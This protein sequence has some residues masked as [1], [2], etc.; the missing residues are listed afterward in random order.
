MKKLVLAAFALTA[1]ASVFAQGTVF[2]NNRIAGG[3][4]TGL[5]LHVF[6]P[7]TTA[8][9]LS[10]IGL[11][12]NDTGGS[13]NVTNAWGS[14]APQSANLGSVS[15][16]PLIGAGGS[17]GKYGYATTFAQLI[18]A[19]GLNAAEGSL[20]P[21][22]PTTTFRTGSSLGSVAVMSVTLS[23]IPKDAAA[24]TFEFVAWDASAAIAGYDLTSWGIAGQKKAFDAWQAG[25]IAGGHSAPFNST[26]I[27]GDLNPIINLN[28]DSGN[29]GGMTSFNLYMIPE[30]STFALA[31]LG[32]AAMLVLRR[33]S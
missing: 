19:N 28:A 29:P 16:M 17:G 2:F 31:G 25:L 7:S 20:V 10:L 27:G 13:A 22:S 5:S 8:P 32:L 24:A 15:S 1:A 3:V 23:S 6:A 21:Q 26:K 30:P 9:G 18:G 33:R 11:G 12:S 4:G 14:I